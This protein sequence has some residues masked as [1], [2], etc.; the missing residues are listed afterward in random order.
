MLKDD[1]EWLLTI[2]DSKK[3]QLEFNQKLFEIMEGNLLKYVLDALK[4][5]LSANAF[6]TASKRVVPINIL[7]RIVNKLSK[8]YSV[9]PKRT[10]EIESDQLLV[11]LYS[12][13]GV[14][15]KFYG[16]HN[17]NFNS[18]KYSALEFFIEDRIL[19]QRAIPATQFIVASNDKVNPLRV[20]HYS[21]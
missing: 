19:K 21:M 1:I 3:P 4:S 12:Q 5:Q 6:E 7:R 16:N 20:T 2:I 8:L 11:D 10:T 9:S 13:N 18:Y 17:L 15:D 14:L